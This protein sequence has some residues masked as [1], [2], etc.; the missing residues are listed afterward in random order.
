MKELEAL[1]DNF[2]IKE[3]KVIN[4]EEKVKEEKK[5]SK[6]GIK[7]V[8]QPK[9]LYRK[10]V[11]LRKKQSQKADHLRGSFDAILLRKSLK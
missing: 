6:L 2:G 7:L 4:L 5:I 8:H 3:T 9:K 11:D 1:P 10:G